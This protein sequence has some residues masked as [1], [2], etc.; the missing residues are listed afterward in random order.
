ML[1]KISFIGLLISAVL[2]FSLSNILMMVV[3]LLLA[4][5][6]NVLSFFFVS[7]S[8]RPHHE[9][10]KETVYR[11]EAMGATEEEIL[12]FMDAPQRMRTIYF[13]TR[14]SSHLGSCRAYGS[15]LYLGM[16]CLL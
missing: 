8:V 16:L 14:A 12:E 1:G 7:I 6:I 10:F 11:M 5:V 4:L 9:R 13:Q 15:V 2:W 3:S